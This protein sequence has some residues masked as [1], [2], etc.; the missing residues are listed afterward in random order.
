MPLKPTVSVCIPAYNA[1]RFIDEAVRSVLEQTFDDFELV[2]VD[3][4]SGDGTVERIEAYRDNR[5]RIF[6]NPENIGAAANW[7]RAVGLARGRFVKILCSDDVLRPGALSRQ[8]KIL[9]AHPGVALAAGRRDIVDETGRV[10][11]RGRGLGRL[12]GVVPGHEALKATVRSGT[13]LFGEPACVLLRREFMARCGAFSASRQYMIDL[14]YWC[15]MLRF[16]PLFAQEETVAAFRVSLQA[17]SVE[18]VRQQ[19]SQ[20][21]QLFGDLHRDSPASVAGQDVAR[22]ALRAR[23]LAAA[24]SASYRLLAVVTP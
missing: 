21:I 11:I 8:V 14:D 24:R 10:L 12:R 3:D 23:T 13:N 4:A 19:S 1:A 17:W 2:V 18:L 15:R 9:E 6:R 16:G 20:A 22:G 7:N 5:I